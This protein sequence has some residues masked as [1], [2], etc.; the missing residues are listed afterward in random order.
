MVAL[1]E[2]RAEYVPLVDDHLV[3]L[4]LALLLGLGLLDDVLEA[5]DVVLLVLDDILGGAYGLLDAVLLELGL[6][7]LLDDLVELVILLHEVRILGLDLLLELVDL[8]R[9]AR[10]LLGQLGDLLLA[11]EEVLRVEVAVA[12]HGLVEVLLVL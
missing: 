9:H 5:G 1:D 7:V 6:A 12:A 8:V 2:L 11:L 3:V 4:L 10:V